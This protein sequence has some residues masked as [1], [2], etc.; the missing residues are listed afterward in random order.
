MASIVQRLYERKLIDP[1]S[2][3]TNNVHYET[4]MGSVAYGVSSDTSDVDVYGF[5]IPPKNMIFPHLAGEIPG[6]GAQK[7]RF[8]VYQQH[9][10]EEA[11]ERKIY[12]LSIFSIVKYVSLCID[13]N[14]NMIDSLFT[15]D[16]CVLHITEVGQM[17]RSAREFFLHKGC[18]H[19]F[20]GYAYSQLHKCKNKNPEGK[21]KETVEKYGF[22]IKFAYHV[23]RL[24]QEVEQIMS[25]GTLDLL[26]GREY[27]KAIRRGDVKLEDIE[28]WFSEKEL[29]LEKLYHESHLP[30]KPD[31]QKIKKLLL[32]C[33]EHHYGSLDTAIRIEGR[34]LDAI[35][36]IKE[37]VNKF[38]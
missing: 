12:D 11:N 6:F 3:L 13:N 30:Y 32:D 7:Q 8:E 9:H 18:W 1:P 20:K 34:E 14:P 17:I 24:I 37:I 22:D 38:S 4:M 5:C 16:F 15:P 36:E 27:L 26:R 33:F 21:R 10:I 28:K 29:S 35:R 2:F 31:E 25:E 19:K 23:V